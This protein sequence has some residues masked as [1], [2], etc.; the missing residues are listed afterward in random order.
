MSVLDLTGVSLVGA[1]FDMTVADSFTPPPGGVGVPQA[2]EHALEAL[3]G[4]HG[5]PLLEKIGGFVNQSPGEL[6]Q[7]IFTMGMKLPLAAMARNYFEREADYL[8]ECVPIGKGH[9]LVWEENNQFNIV[10]ELF[11]RAKLRPLVAQISKT[12]PVPS[13]GFFEFVQSLRGFGI[14][15]G[16]ITAGHDVFIQ[17]F[18]AVHEV[19]VPVL[20][21]G[22]D[23]RGSKH[24]GIEK[25][26]AKLFELFLEKFGWMQP[27]AASSILYLGDDINRDG[28]LA[29]NTGVRFGLYSPFTVY[30]ERNW[31][32]R[33]FQFGHFSDLTHALRAGQMQAAE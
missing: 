16:I 5:K 25:P 19:E 8:R 2:C 33:T 20:L 12:W 17:N 4:E 27:I 26:D 6:M 28:G 30:S 10:L 1:D 3:F 21:T 31:S 23:I 13:P 9:P 11:V 24:D 32:P 14:P 22:D 29:H 7:A 18:F 15:F